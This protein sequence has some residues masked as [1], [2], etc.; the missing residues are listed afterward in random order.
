MWRGD[1]TESERFEINRALFQ[2]RIDSS[3]FD[4]LFHE[5]EQLGSVGGTFSSQLQL[6]GSHCRFT[7]AARPS[8]AVSFEQGSR[9]I[10][11]DWPFT[12]FSND[13]Y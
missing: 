2:Q 10:F 6:S 4:E 9:L 13:N 8:V 12:D 11:S 3:H 5:P 7:F 1:F